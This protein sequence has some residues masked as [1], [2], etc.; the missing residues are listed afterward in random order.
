MD[1]AK[2]H[3]PARTASFLSYVGCGLLM[4]G[5]YASSDNAIEYVH[6]I[7]KCYLR[8]APWFARL[9]PDTALYMVGDLI[10]PQQCANIMR[11]VMRM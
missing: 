8:R 3:D 2:F 1:R 7:E 10:T 11:H 4:L 6:H 5:P 9:C